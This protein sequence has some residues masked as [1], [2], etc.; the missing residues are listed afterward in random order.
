[1]AKNQ[2]NTI[3]KERQD[4]GGGR[5]KRQRWKQLECEV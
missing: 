1:M 4:E 5:G 3:M 2:I